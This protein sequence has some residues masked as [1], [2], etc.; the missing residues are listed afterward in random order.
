MIFLSSPAMIT[1]HDES[2]SVGVSLRPDIRFRRSRLDLSFET[3]LKIQSIPPFGH[4]AA[5]LSAVLAFFKLIEAR[6]CAPRLRMVAQ[7]SRHFP[8]IAQTKALRERFSLQ[9]SLHFV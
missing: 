3:S 9:P 7:F 8:Y 6:A 4:L 5:N 1:P 2:M